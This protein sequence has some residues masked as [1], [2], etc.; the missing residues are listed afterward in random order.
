MDA[1]KFIEKALS[2]Y[3]VAFYFSAVQ[4]FEKRIM[5][6][7]CR[8][9]RFREMRDKYDVLFK[10]FDEAYKRTNKS[11]LTEKIRLLDAE[12]DGYAYVIQKVADLWA[13]KLEDTSLAEHGKRVGQVF[14]DYKFRN[15]EALVAENA[16]IHNM[17]QKLSERELTAD[18]QAMGL[19]E[20][21]RRLL[22][23]TE[24]IE[25]LMGKRNEEKSDVVVG[26]LKAAREALDGHYRAFITYLNA[27][28]ELQPEESL[29]KAAQFYNAD[30]AKID[31]QYQQ[32]RK[33]GGKEDEPA[34]TTP[35]NVE[36]EG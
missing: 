8:L 29:S 9:D 33:K 22:S 13:E 15:R 25:E 12:R 27:V 23:R 1:T 26:E 2:N 28:Q 21:N 18:L 36:D 24:Q 19:T 11:E 7:D 30:L 16:K 20:L 14:V 31:L 35:A 6:A 3:P 4:S 10:A 5:A 34:T 17:E 32:S